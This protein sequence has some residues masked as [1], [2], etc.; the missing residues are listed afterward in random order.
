MQEAVC[1]LLDRFNSLITQS[2][3]ETDEADRLLSIFK[4]VAWL[5]F[6][7]LDL[8]PFSDGNGRLC[9]LLCS[10]SMFSQRTHLFLHL[11]IIRANTCTLLLLPGNPNILTN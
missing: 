3:N 1:T 8:H 7:L 2:I 10:Y 11:S 4:S 5:V 6:E 9:R